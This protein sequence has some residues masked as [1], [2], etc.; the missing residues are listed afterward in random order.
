MLLNREVGD[1]WMVAI[2][3]N[4]LGN[5]T[6]GLGDYETARRHYAEG[7][8]A[9]RDYDDRWALAFLLED[10][11]ILAAL[12]GDPQSALALIGAA[13]A[14][15]EAIGA[16]RAPSLEQAI[17]QQIGPAVAALSEQDRLAHRAKRRSLDL[18]AAIARALPLCERCAS[19]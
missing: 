18:A 5:A 1:T 7:P 4:N 12:S 6:R 2:C 16:P 14:S 10:I 11:G 3:Q 15:R 8:R 19:G 9:Y 17:A 13:D